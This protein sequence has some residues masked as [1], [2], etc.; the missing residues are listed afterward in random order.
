M[1]CLDSFIIGMS[2]NKTYTNTA[3][4]IKNWGTAGNYHWVVVDQGSS[5]YRIQ[6]YKQIDL[7]G[8]EMLGT[9]QTTLGPND[10]GIVS[11]YSFEIGI[12]GQQPLVSGQIQAAP[13]DWVLIE[14]Q[15]K[16]DLGK[17]SN[18]LTLE[19]PFAGCTSIG[20]NE[21]KVQG[22]NGETLNS[23]NLDIRL[24][25]VFHYKYEI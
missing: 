12:N 23:L 20:F 15:A 19:T 6:G 1:E 16:F 25:F 8:V 17:Y 5:V 7:Y 21:L 2:L 18:K 10:G 3:T 13:N 22:Q 11:D 24:Q 9:I 4:N 14:K